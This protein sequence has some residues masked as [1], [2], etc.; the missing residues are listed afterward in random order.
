MIL[1]HFPRHDMVVLG[2]YWEGTNLKLVLYIEYARRY[3]EENCV[4]IFVFTLCNQETPKQV[5]LQTVKT[6]MKC[7]IM[8]HLIRVYLFVKVKKIFRQKNTS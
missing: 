2:S 5:I 4:F 1:R 6:Q 7:S 3:V 8:L